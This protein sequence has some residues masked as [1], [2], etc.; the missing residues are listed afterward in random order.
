MPEV[1]TKSLC[2]SVKVSCH[3]KHEKN[4]FHS[5]QF[6]GCHTPFE[7]HSLAPQETSTLNNSTACIQAGSNKT[8]ELTSFS[9]TDDS[10]Q[11]HPPQRK[12][13]HDQTCSTKFSEPSHF[14][15]AC[16]H[17]RKHAPQS[18]WLTS[19]KN[20]QVPFDWLMNWLQKFSFMERRHKN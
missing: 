8:L 9:E 12:G 16:G 10:Y 20:I 2:S 19:R 7:F 5:I 6:C 14:D 11:R 1:L 4:D 15:L 3:K 17:S 13:F 18:D